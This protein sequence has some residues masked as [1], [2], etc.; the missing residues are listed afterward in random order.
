MKAGNVRYRT[1]EDIPESVPIFPLSGAL[2]LPGG[3]LPLNIFE[4][5]Y[6]AMIDAALSGKRIIGMIQP[7]FDQEEGEEAELCEVG[8]LGRI[9]SFAETGD[10]RV[11]ITLQGI[12]R[13]RIVKELGT[14]APFRQCKIAP[15][16]A[17]LDE[18]DES[19]VDRAAL[20]RVFRAY[21][22]AN[23]LEADWDGI[24]RAGN[25][26]LVNALAMMSPFGAA[27]KQALLEAADLK[28]RA[29]TLIAITEIA[30]A[31][32]EDGFEGSLQ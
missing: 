8:C 28:T 12:C 1:L 26:T 25:E 15:L 21:L 14:R 7:R 9:T 16:R 27:E 20:L 19:E 6:L 22:D 10:G 2:L 13:F 29:E 17:D 31:K 3:Q 4:P 23:S 18:A 30:L 11:L 32:D 24:A 5:R